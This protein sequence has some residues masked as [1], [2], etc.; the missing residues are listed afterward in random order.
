MTAAVTGEAGLDPELEALRAE[1]WE[2]TKDHPDSCDCVP[3]WEYYIV[4]EK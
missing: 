3:C 1:L 2:Q 4:T